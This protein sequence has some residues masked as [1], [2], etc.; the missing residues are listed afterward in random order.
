[1]G[2]KRLSS[3]G[4]HNNDNGILAALTN[5]SQFTVKVS[6]SREELSMAKSGISINI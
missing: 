6:P 1:M 3:C 5:H 2:L 4:Q